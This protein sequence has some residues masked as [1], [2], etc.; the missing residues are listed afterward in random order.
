MVSEHCKGRDVERVGNDAILGA[1][2][3]QAGVE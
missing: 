2:S 3:E 1:V